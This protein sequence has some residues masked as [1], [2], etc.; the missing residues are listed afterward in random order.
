MEAI[1]GHSEAK[2]K[3]CHCGIYALKEQDRCLA[4]GDVVG[5]VALWGFI[6]EH[7]HGYRAQYAY[8]L[9]I[10]VPSNYDETD[11][12]RL[13][14]YGVPIERVKSDPNSKMDAIAYQFVLNAQAQAQYQAY[15]QLINYY[16]APLTGLLGAVPFPASPAP[17]YPSPSG[18]TLGVDVADVKKMRKKRGFFSR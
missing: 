8:P 5:E 12:Y 3:C 14:E 13:E 2:E 18:L 17:R 16:S 4:W 9:N 6:E 10:K 15:Q 11:T 1:C 7:E